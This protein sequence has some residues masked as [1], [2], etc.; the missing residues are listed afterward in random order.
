[1]PTMT[2]W[3]RSWVTLVEAYEAD[4]HTSHLSAVLNRKRSLS[5]SQI[6][7]LSVAMDIPSGRVIDT[8]DVEPLSV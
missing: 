5:L 4:V 6:K 2:M 8:S 1:M 3:T 7:K